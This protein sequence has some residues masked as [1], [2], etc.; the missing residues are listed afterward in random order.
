MRKLKPFDFKHI[1]W[2]IRVTNIQNFKNQLGMNSYRCKLKLNKEE[3]KFEIPIK[4]INA[5]DKNDLEFQI[6]V[7]LRQM[8][9]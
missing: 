4:E 5:K 3:Q 9:Y 1:Y 8:N 7:I 2:N 6:K